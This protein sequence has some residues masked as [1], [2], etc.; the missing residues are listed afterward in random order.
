MISP[1]PA[2]LSNPTTPSQEAASEARPNE[3]VRACTSLLACLHNTVRPNSKNPPK[4][5]IQKNHEIDLYLQW[6]DN[7]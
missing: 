4:S 1:I 3:S 5:G 7:F 2:K 6:F